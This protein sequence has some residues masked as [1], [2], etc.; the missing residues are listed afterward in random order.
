MTPVALIDRLDAHLTAADELSAAAHAE[1]RRHAPIRRGVLTGT[2]RRLAS[3]CRRFAHE[4]DMAVEMA[5]A[6]RSEREEV[7]A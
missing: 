6:G 4:L 7:T 1:H 2:M 3:E 5:A